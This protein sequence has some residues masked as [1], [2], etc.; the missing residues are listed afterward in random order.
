MVSV[1][2][3]TPAW[4]RQELP[5]WPGRALWH[6]QWADPKVFFK[7]NA[8]TRQAAR[9][10]LRQRLEFPADTRILVFAGRFEKQK[11][12]PLL[13]EIFE[14]ATSE[15]E[16]LG[17]ILIGEGRL[18]PH[19][20]KRIEER[21]LGRRVR[22]LTPVPRAGL[23]KVY[24]GC[25]VAVCTSGFE[26]GPRFVF[27]AAACGLPVVSFDVG[28]VARLVDHD[29]MFGSLVHDRTAAAFVGR[30]I[31]VMATPTDDER[32]DRCARNAARFTP[33]SGLRPIIDAYTSL[34]G[35]DAGLL[36]RPRRLRQ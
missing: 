8:A 2:P 35:S 34:L 36:E 14:Q 32:A 9:V 22:I 17:L 24:R 13:L 18:R 7:G 12:V 30:L 10:E 28:Q 4:V 19:L 26:A 15:L 25:D 33:E 29:L 31:A 21:E 20:R 1:D 16:N 5:D 3:R 6:Q 11:D 23:A 27:E